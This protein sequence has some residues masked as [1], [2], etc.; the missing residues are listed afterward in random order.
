MTDVP[1]ILR[2]AIQ[3]DLGG[4]LAWLDIRLCPDYMASSVLSSI[5]YFLKVPNEK[6]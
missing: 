3:G 6:N 4:Q 5:N 2:A 1:K